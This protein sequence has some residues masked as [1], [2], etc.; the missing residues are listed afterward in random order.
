MYEQK[1]V[2]LSLSL[3]LFANVIHF[4]RAFIRSHYRYRFLKPLSVGNTH[5]NTHAQAQQKHAH[6]C[7]HRRTTYIYSMTS[8]S[9]VCFRSF[10]LFFLSFSCSLSLN[11]RHSGTILFK[12]IFRKPKEL[13]FMHAYSFFIR[14]PFAALC[15]Q[16][17]QNI[18]MYVCICM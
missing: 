3:S 2:L 7:T 4:Y 11:F 9:F 15:A 8:A 6:T 16:A 18:C 5:T 13:L 14:L 12:V 10:A 17:G 1:P